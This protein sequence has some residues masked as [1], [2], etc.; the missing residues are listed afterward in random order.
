MAPKAVSVSAAR[1]GRGGLS[2]VRKYGGRLHV[3]RWPRVGVYG[4]KPTRSLPRGPVPHRGA[5]KFKRTSH[6]A[7]PCE[8]CDSTQSSCCCNFRFVGPLPVWLSAWASPILPAA[9]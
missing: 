9:S 3:I 7:A 2:A 1:P 8:D 4:D 5:A 6:A